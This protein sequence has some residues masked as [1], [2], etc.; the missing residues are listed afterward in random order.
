[1]I[2]GARRTITEVGQLQLADRK[3][4]SSTTEWSVTEV[5]EAIYQLG[6]VRAPVEDSENLETEGLELGQ[7]LEA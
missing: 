2:H 3:I 4:D 7:G 5:V 6:G 1:M